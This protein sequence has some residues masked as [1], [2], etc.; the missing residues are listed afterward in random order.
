MNVFTRLMGFILV[1]IG[2]Q[3]ILTGIFEGLSDPEIIAPIVA[4]FRVT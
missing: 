2:I 3:F 4:A 1:C